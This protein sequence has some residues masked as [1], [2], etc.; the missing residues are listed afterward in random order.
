MH[1]YSV[2]ITDQNGND[3][4]WEWRFTDACRSC[5]EKLINNWLRARVG[6]G[7][8]ISLD[9]NDGDI[10][11]IMPIRIPDYI[12]E[13]KVVE[14]H[15]YDGHLA[16]IDGKFSSDFLSSTSG[17]IHGESV[18]SE[19]FFVNIYFEE[20]DP[21]SVNA[22]DSPLWLDLKPG[23]VVIEKMIN[24]VLYHSIKR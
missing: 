3:I 20:G 2:S 21:I 16:S 13:R 10:V 4:E 11:E 15:K 5:R 18:G 17:N 12:R 24:G 7:V 19:D 8:E 9:Y 14:V 6:Q 22:K 1:P 23:D